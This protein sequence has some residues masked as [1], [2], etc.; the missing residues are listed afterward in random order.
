MPK[1]KKI[2]SAKAAEEDV[3]AKDAAK[4]EKTAEAEP[5]KEAAKTDE[6]TADETAEPEKAAVEAGEKNNSEASKG[7]KMN[8][9]GKK[10]LVIE[11]DSMLSSMYRMKLEDHGYQA[12]TASDGKTGLEIARKENPDLILLDIMMPMVDGF[13][14]LAEMRSDSSLKKVPVIIMTNL[15]TNEDVEKGK[16][17]GATDYIVKADVTPSQIVEKIQKYL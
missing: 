14:V 12:F 11:D 16:K 5:E 8:P 2:K 15:G 6:K 17:L 10:I 4:E 7:K 3:E 9:G 13:S 1:T